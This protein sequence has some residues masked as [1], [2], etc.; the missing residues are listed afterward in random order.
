MQEIQEYFDEVTYETCGMC[1]VCISKR[2]TENLAALKD[3]EQQILYLLKQKSMTVEELEAA[4]E[5]AEK[6]LFIEVVREMV[7]AAQIAYDEF[8]VLAIKK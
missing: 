5:P 2:K 7:D 8:W 4:V 3:Y 1:D 6:E